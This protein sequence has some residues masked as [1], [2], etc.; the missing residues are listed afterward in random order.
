MGIRAVKKDPVSKPASPRAA[1][2]RGPVD[3]YLPSAGNHGYTVTRY[4]LDLT[5]KVSSNHLR[6]TATITATATEPLKSFSLDMATHL[7]PSK[8]S[9]AP[10]KVARFSRSRGKLT[11]K[12]ADPIEVG[13]AFT[14]TIRYSGNPRPVGGHWGE[15]GWEELTDGVLV[16]GQPNGAAS[17]F[18]CDDHPSSKAPYRITFTTDSPYRAVVTG[19][20]VGKKTGGS[21]TTWEYD[22]PYPTPPYLVSVGI[23]RYEHLEITGAPA[24][25]HAYVPSDLVRPFRHAFRKQ[26]DMLSVFSDLF[27]PYPFD[28]YSV[29]VTDDELEVPLEAMGMSTFGRQTCESDDDADERLIAHELAHQWFGNA[30]TAERWQDIWLHE[31]FACYA[32]W[33]WSEFSGGSDAGTHALRYY[34]KLQHSPRDLLLADP[35]A[36]DMFDDRVYKRG[37]L[38]LHA[39]RTVIGDEEFFAVLREWVELHSGETVTTRDFLDLA[40][41]HTELDL[42]PLWDAWLY[43]TDLPAT[44]GLPDGS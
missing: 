34:S 23:G 8:V 44:F 3:P 10:G 17:W 32:E 18:P 37:A 7:D 33:L 25:I 15:V 42:R 31:G 43:S 2:R 5:Y 6:G 13:A 21:M 4:E 1:S 9:L 40:A 12:P 16:A 14:V 39:L 30:V 36:A 29:V 11:V 27:G 28:Q 19:N 24:R 26:A 22:L 20:L 38:T 35:G 41:R